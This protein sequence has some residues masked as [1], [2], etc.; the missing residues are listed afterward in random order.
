MLEEVQ[1][2]IKESGLYIQ[3]N[4]VGAPRCYKV[5]SGPSWAEGKQGW[6]GGTNDDDDRETTVRVGAAQTPATLPAG[7]GRRHPSFSR[8]SSDPRPM[9]LG[10]GI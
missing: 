1:N 9:L 4:Q 5:M 7:R 10:V 8:R 2:Y 6:P 3:K